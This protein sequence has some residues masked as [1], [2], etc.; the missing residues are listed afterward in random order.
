MALVRALITADHLAIIGFDEPGLALKRLN[1]WFLVNTQNN[2]FFRRIQIQTDNIGGL[3]SE[4][5]IRAD[6]P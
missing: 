3:G 4:L 1:A 5:R 6:A 2:G